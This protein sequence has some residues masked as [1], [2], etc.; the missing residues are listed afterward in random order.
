MS[1]GELSRELRDGR[2]NWYHRTHHEIRVLWAS[3]VTQHSSESFSL[4]VALRQTWFVF[5]LLPFLVPVALLGVDAKIVMASY[6]INLLYQFRIHTELVDKLWA[7][8]EFLFNTASHHRAHHGTNNEYLDKNYGGIL[9][10]WDRL[11]GTFEAERARVIYGLTKNIKTYNVVRIETHEYAAIWRGVK[12]AASWRAK[13]GHL[14]RGPGWQPAAA[15][16]ATNNKAVR[17]PGWTR[18]SAS[19]LAAAATAFALIVHSTGSSRPP[20]PRARFCARQD[21]PT[22]RVGCWSRGCLIWW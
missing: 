18:P 15:V 11:F 4:S 8:I 3:H 5:T 2:E 1:S 16:P 20:R 13:L 7:P 21:K 19:L 10:I 14:F 17:Q 9:I 12:A 6:S 22:T